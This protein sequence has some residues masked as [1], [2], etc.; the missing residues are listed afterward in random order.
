[1]VLGSPPTVLETFKARFAT[2]SS[3]QEPT[4]WVEV[5]VFLV[6]VDIAS[7]NRIAII[8]LEWN[9]EKVVFQDFIGKDWPFYSFMMAEALPECQWVVRRADSRGEELFWLQFLSCEQLAR[10]EAR[11]ELGR[12]LVNVYHRSIHLQLMSSS[13]VFLPPHDDLLVAG[14]R[15]ESRAFS[16]FPPTPSDHVSPKV[17]VKTEANAGEAASD[18]RAGCGRRGSNKL[19]RVIGFLFSG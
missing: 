16:A 4:D 7:F 17:P 8:I 13:N 12:E 19:M 5:V 6:S 9:S 2:E 14:G 18:V 3:S 1:M 15:A 11:F 10:F